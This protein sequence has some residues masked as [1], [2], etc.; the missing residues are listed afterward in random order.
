MSHEKNTERDNFMK[1]PNLIFVNPLVKNT[2]QSCTLHLNETA[3]I[4]EN[5]LANEL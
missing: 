5:I 3:K 1:L 4:F 2:F